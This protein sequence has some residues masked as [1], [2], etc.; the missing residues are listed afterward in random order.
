MLHPNMLLRHVDRISCF[1]YSMAEIMAWWPCWKSV[2]ILN[3]WEGR[4]HF[5][6][7]YGV[8][9]EIKC[10]VLQFERILYFWSVVCWTIAHYVSYNGVIYGLRGVSVD[11]DSKLTHCTCLAMITKI[12]T[13]FK[14]INKTMSD[15]SRKN[16]FLG[17]KALE[18]TSNSWRWPLIAKISYFY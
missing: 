13:I 7:E 2:A 15:I 8:F 3:L 9:V 16:T 6:K 1:F 17:W 12:V 11:L 5:L 10:F 14:A 18:L 4:I